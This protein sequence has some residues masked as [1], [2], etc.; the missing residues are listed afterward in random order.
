MN[1]GQV[2]IFASPNLLLII[3]FLIETIDKHKILELAH[4]VLNII[5]E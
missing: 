3:D 1:I 4:S 2:I 5:S